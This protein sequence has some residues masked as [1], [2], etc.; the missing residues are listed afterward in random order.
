[1]LTSDYGAG[2]AG[3]VA[4]GGGVPGRAATGNPLWILVIA[5]NHVRAGTLPP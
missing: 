4:A 5:S 1:M 3:G 2:A